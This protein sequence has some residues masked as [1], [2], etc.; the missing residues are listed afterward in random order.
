VLVLD[1]HAWIWLVDRPSRLGRKARALIAAG[2]RLGVASISAWEVAM[3]HGHG[4][5]ELDR[6]VADWV[7]QALARPGL[8]EIPLTAPVAVAAALLPDDFP[9]D[10]ADRIIYANARAER[11]VLVTRDVRLREVDPAGTVW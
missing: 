9:R 2:E 10:P 5:I 4:R 7:A 6:P 11:A 1:T 3:L 8:N